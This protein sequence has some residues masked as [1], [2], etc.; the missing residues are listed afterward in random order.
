M[1]EFVKYRGEEPGVRALLGHNIRINRLADGLVA[2]S[3]T[4]LD[5]E[6][7]SLKGRSWSCFLA[8][9]TFS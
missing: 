7:F 8:S 6:V 4:G 2:L 9:A 1:N 5:I 3:T